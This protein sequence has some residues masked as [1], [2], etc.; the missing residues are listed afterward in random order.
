MSTALSAKARALLNE[1]H[2]AVLATLN[3]DGSPQLTTMWYLLE[4]V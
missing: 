1:T 3:S 4:E 2:F